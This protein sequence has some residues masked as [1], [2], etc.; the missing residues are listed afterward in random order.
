VKADAYKDLLST[1]RQMH[2]LDAGDCISVSDDLPQH[3]EM[4][5]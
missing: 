2:K 5:I 1:S 4:M 3:I